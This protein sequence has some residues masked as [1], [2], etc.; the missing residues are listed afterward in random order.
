MWELNVDPEAGGGPDL[1]AIV[2]SPDVRT[3]ASLPTKGPL[4]VIVP[5]VQGLRQQ[6]QD[7]QSLLTSIKDTIRENDADRS[8]K[9][10]KLEV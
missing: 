10:K 2:T 5:N 9:E 4:P 6:L 3:P 7:Q 8:S 1:P